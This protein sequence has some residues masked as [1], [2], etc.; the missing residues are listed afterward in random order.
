MTDPIDIA[1]PD[2]SLSG[3]IAPKSEVH[4]NGLYHH[5]GHLWLYTSNKHI[6]LQQRAATKIICPLLWD[7]SVAGHIDAGETIEQGLIREAKEEIGL[8]LAFDELNKIGVFKFFQSYPNGMIDNEFHNTYIAEL[9]TDLK[10]LKPQ[11][12]EVEALKLVSFDTF[13]ILLEQSETNQHF[14]ASN[15]P[16]YKKV[17]DAI[18]AE[19]S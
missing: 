4:S 13:E 2:G 3:K 10:K 7:V 12:E 16:Y 14:V 6:L 15:R 11:K 18:K 19:F 5:T 17:L 1:N 8:D 9:K